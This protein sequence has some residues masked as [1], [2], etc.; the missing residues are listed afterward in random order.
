[1][2]QGGPVPDD[3]VEM[4]ARHLGITIGVPSPCPKETSEARHRGL[5]V[6]H[7]AKKGEEEK[8]GYK[9][10]YSRHRGGWKDDSQWSSGGSNY[11]GSSGSRG[12][13]GRGQ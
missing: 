13:Y 5:K 3:E 4:W 6:G 11:G 1:M 7:H 12:H 2:S 9:R 8:R 10:D